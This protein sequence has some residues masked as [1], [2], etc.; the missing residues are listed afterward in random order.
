MEVVLNY[1]I[2]CWLKRWK[3]HNLF[4]SDCEK[5]SRVMIM[6]ISRTVLIRRESHYSICWVCEVELKVSLKLVDEHPTLSSP[7]PSE[8]F[9]KLWIIRAEE[10]LLLAKE[11]N[12]Y[13][14]NAKRL[15]V[16]KAIFN[17]VPTLL[18]TFFQLALIS[19][20]GYFAQL[21]IRD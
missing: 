12:Y 3:P 10:K 8:G 4:I 20:K 11:I 19:K 17:T 2:P 15:F 18:V 6:S 9:W 7:L 14:E 13:Q 16:I 1:T 5:L 21:K